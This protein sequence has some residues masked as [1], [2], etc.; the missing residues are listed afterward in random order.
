MKKEM[1]ENFIQY[2]EERFTK[3]IVYREGDSTVFILN[4]MPNQALP[5]HKH[6]GTNVYLLVLDGDGTF[7]INQKPVKV[8]KN[9]V[10][11]CTGDEELSFVNDGAQNVSLYVMLNKIPDDHYTKDI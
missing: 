11:L 3:R 2:T 7:S 10:I 6:P 4:F 8:K 9:D 1:L 5:A